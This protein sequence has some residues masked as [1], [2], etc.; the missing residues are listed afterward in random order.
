MERLLTQKQNFN[1][2]VDM[3]LVNFIN[4]L[5]INNYKCLL[6]LVYFFLLLLFFPP[7][8]FN[9]KPRDNY[10]FPPKRQL[11]SFSKMERR[12]EEESYHREVIL[13]EL[14]EERFLEMVSL[15]LDEK[16]GALVLPQEEAVHVRW[17]LTLWLYLFT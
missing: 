6:M 3:Q 11:S 4:F 16:K 1:Q 12:G 5:L 17:V 9:S 7:L 2:S 13:N 10:R 8:N 14:N 15:F